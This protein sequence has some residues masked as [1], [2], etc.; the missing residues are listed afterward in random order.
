MSFAEHFK[1]TRVKRALTQ[2]ETGALLGV[3]EFTILS[4]EKG[5]TTPTIGDLPKVEAFIGYA[6]APPAQ[7]LGERMREYRWKNGLAIREAARLAGVSEDG[8][9]EWERAGII[10][11][12]RCLE[13][14]EKVLVLTESSPPTP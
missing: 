14:V 12:K 7:S 3:S 11:N 6:L 4:W 1:A 9:A 5:R 10:K 8:W 2:K 13:A